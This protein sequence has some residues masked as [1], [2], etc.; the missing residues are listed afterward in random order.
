LIAHQKIWKPVTKTN[1][2]TTEANRRAFLDKFA[3]ARGF[4][5]LIAENWYPIDSVTLR[6]QVVYFL[7]V[8]PEILRDLQAPR[9]ASY[10]NDSHIKAIM[11]LYPDIGLEA[12][13][14]KSPPSTLLYVI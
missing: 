11:Q 1:D 8:L 12:E 7:N 6:S 14:F 4:D 13:K 2:W 10:Y 3:Q 5:P 9:L